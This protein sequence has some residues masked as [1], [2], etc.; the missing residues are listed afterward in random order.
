[1]KKIP[2][3]NNNKTQNSNPVEPNA[4]PVVTPIMPAYSLQGVTLNNVNKL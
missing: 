3:Q 1:M 4:L 2:I